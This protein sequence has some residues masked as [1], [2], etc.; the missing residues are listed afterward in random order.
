MARPLSWSRGV[1]SALLV[2]L[3]C[4]LTATTS[5]ATERPKAATILRRADLVR[6]PYVGTALDIDLSVVSLATLREL[7]GSRY[8]MLTHRNDRT[9]ILM[10]QRDRT[11]PAALL[12]ADDIYWLLLP[13]AERPV[14]LALRHVV[15]GDLSQAGFLRVNLRTRYEPHYD[16]EETLG[17]VPCWRLELE[18]K[19]EPA[20]FGRVR[21]WVAQRSF[22]PI[23][24][25]YYSEAGEL[26]KTARFTAYQDTGMGPRPARIEIDDTRR[27]RERTRLTL[28]KPRG[29]K[30]S[31]LDFDVDDLMAL[32]R[33]AR[34]LAVDS[35]APVDG[36]QLVEALAASAR[37]H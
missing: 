2:G 1:W 32:R 18:P 34:R 15:A 33:A 20:P 12:I 9:L 26:L 14:E 31:N 7:R 11:A 23:R 16:G 17:D 22:L 24:I 29:V 4:V 28:A 21:Y 35:E 25:E 6:N 10:P 13:Q 8:T 3:S 5:T 27:P 19:S 30:T 37:A 36:K